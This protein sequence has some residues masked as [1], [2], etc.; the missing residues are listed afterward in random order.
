PDTTKRYISTT[1]RYSLIFAAAIA[2]VFAANPRDLL[3]IPYSSD[4]ASIGAM[5]LVGLALGNV[6]FSIFVIAGTILNGA[7][8][9]RDAIVTAGV[10]LVLAAVSNA[11]VIPRFDPGPELLLAC[12]CATGGSMLAGA[13]LGGVFLRK[14]FGA[15]VPA[16]TVI[17]VLIAGAAAIGA[18][19]VI[20]ASSALMVLA[21][22]TAIGILF[23]VVLVASRE[24]TM[25]D[26]RS[27]TGVLGK[28]K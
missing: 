22:A 26:L 27:F 13:I 16:A 28:E 5:A 23:V 7:G 21:E 1:M 9:T 25:K 10:T 19:R 8:N 15:F 12:A 11:V 20:P 17:R 2:V 6:A 3:D 4:Y 18:G 14:R 24:L